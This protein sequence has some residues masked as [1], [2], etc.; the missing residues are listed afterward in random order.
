MLDL[1]FVSNV[2]GWLYVTAW[3]I[4][5]YPQIFLN[6]KLRS[7]EGLKLDY[8]F[9]N[10]TGF[11][12]CS[13]AYSIAFFNKDL[14]LDHYGYGTIRIQDLVFIYHNLFTNAVLNI[15]GIFYKRGKN[16]LS[17][18]SIL[19]VIFVIILTVVIYLLSEVHNIIKPTERFNILLFL[20]FVKISMS[21]FKYIPLVYWNY[22]RKSTKGFSMTA[23]MFDFTGGVLS[24]SQEIIDYVDQTTAVM[25]PI[26]IGI[27]LTAIFYVTILMYQHYFLYGDNE[28]EIQHPPKVIITVE[29]KKEKGWVPLPEE[30]NSAGL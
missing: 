25:N 19:Y 18:Y 4:F 21:F 6:Y 5:S 30:K 1:E 16:T 2:L 29:D 10:V 15:Q 9:L 24:V 13:T 23:F 27:G 28:K 17:W 7:V 12:Y 8:A 11:M 14:P 3:G 20:G 26:K 22:K